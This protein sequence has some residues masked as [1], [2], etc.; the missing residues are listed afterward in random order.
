MALCR[1][2][3]QEDDILYE[4]YVDT[5]SEVSDYSENESLDSDIDVPRTRSCKQL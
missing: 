5:H 1:N 4:L 3:Q 2:V